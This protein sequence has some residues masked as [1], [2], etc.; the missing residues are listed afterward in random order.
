MRT[1]NE[2]TMRSLRNLNQDLQAQAREVKSLMIVSL[3]R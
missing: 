3:Q 2:L 1:E